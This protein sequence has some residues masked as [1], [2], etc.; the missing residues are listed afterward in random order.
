MA[1]DGRIGNAGDSQTIAAEM[2]KREAERVA[3]YGHVR[4]P[5]TMQHKG[6]QFVA[7][8]SRLLF[9]ARWKTFHDF[10]F[11]Y[12]ASI[13]EKEWFVEEARKPVEQRHPLMQW[14]QLLQDFGVAQKVESRKVTKIDA[15]PAQLSALLSFAYDL[16]TL[17]NYGLLPPRLVDRLKRKDQFQG[18]RYEAFVAAALIRAGFTLTLEDEGDLSTT[19]CE[20]TATHQASGRQFSVEAKSRARA[21]FLGQAGTRKPLEE[22]QADISGLLVAALRKAAAHERIVF[23]DINVP[24]S[25]THLLEAE[26]FKK[27][28]SQ[29]ERLAKNQ[30]GPPLPPA[31]VFFTNFPYHFVEDDSALRGA[32]VLFTGFNIPEFH[33]ATADRHAIETKFAP[34][35][36]LHTSL[37]RHTGV[38][39]D[40]D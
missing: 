30:Q 3:K 9:D 23:I 18:A 5:I 34:V 14:Y 29:F 39:H 32:A 35:L 26:W 40:L 10:L 19:H 22:I 31:I 33:G 27:I 36:E 4:A 28:G 16:Y 21:G 1:G 6:Q 15:P 25:E 24:P 20:F 13:I 17:E 2:M 12:I 37:L 7:V 11:T 38:P 8:G